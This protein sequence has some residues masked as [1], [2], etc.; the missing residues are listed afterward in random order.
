MNTLPRTGHRLVIPENNAVAMESFHLRPPEEGEILVETVCSLL[1]TGTETIVYSGKFA[2]GT[3]WDAWVRHPFYPG[4]ASVGIVTAIGDGVEG[5]ALGDRVATRTGHTSHAVLKAE[6]GFRVPETVTSEAAAWFALAKIAGHGI[7]A[8]ELNLGDTVVVIGAGPIG[9]M[10]VRW[11][12]GCGASQVLAVDISPER[13][14][15]AHAAGASSVQASAAEAQTEVLSL[16]GRRPD[17]VIDS[18]GNAE[19]LKSAFRMVEK[20]GTVVLL[21]DTGTP[22]SQSLTGDVISRGLRLV[23]AHDGLN[24]SHWNNKLAAEVFFQFLRTKRFPTEGLITHRFQ[25]SECAEAYEMAVTNRS[26]TMGILFDWSTATAN[27]ADSPF[28][29]EVLLHA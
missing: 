14:A 10:A 26:R 11:A 25:P 19:V 18:T 4:Y 15:L 20:E 6:N 23:G 24:S 17:V 5:L 8:A 16:L 9:Q 2:P 3:H 13:L 1:S 28:T 27:A 29:G 12:L 22:E 21:G 7:R